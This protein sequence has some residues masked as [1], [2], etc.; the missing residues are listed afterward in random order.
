M[1]LCAH[2]VHCWADVRKARGAG[3]AVV[4]TFPH[5]F[6]YFHRVS[7]LFCL[8]GYAGI[9]WY[10]LLLFSSCLPILVLFLAL[11]KVNDCQLYFFF[12]FPKF[13]SGLI[14]VI[15]LNT[16]DLNKSLNEEISVRKLVLSV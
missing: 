6:F 1:S 12:F 16:W 13:R 9:R 15:C 4:L 11:E 7:G 10:F 8:S 3:V 5:R 2:P 14:Y